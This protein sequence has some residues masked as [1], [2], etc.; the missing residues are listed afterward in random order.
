MNPMDSNSNN[1]PSP[2]QN[3]PQPPYP[4]GQPYPTQYQP[5]P[6]RP[7]KPPMDPAKKKKIITIVIISVVAVVV[8]IL[9]II[10]IPIILRVDYSTAYS[11]AKDLQD[12]IY[13]I[14]ND[15]SC[16]KLVEYVDSSSYTEKTYTEWIDTCRDLFDGVD[17]KVTKLGETD[18]IKKDSDLQDKYNTFNAYYAALA[19]S[20]DSLNDKLELYRT[21]HQFAV[22]VSNL[23][24]STSSDTEIQA[25]ANILI[26]SGNDTF[27]TYG[28]G[29]LEKALAS[30]QAYRVYRDTPYDKN[31]S[32]RSTA[33]NDAATALKNYVAENKPVVSDMAKIEIADT[34]KMYQ[35]F[36][37]LYS[38]IADTYAKNYNSGSGDCT[39]FLG[40][41]Y[42]D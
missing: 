16:S 40:E 25:A 32:E 8:L 27:K 36:K 4:N 34:S 28:E 22:A 18:G 11:S 10:L 21:W 38:A 29:W 26:N 42:C 14:Y 17:S 9:A 31:F 33:S 12:D 2:Q 39:E 1:Q 41:V 13:E 3:G 30:A 23:S 5:M 15:R 24:R 20:Q 19:G 35:S 37:T 6:P 7:P